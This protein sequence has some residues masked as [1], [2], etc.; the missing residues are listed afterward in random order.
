MQRISSRVETKWPRS[1]VVWAVIIVLAFGFP[2]VFLSVLYV[3][4]R[5]PL[6]VAP[7]LLFWIWFLWRAFENRRGTWYEFTPE[8]VTVHELSTDWRLRTT[9]RHL[10]L[11][12]REIGHFE[13]ADRE[14]IAFHYSPVERFTVWFAPSD[15]PARLAQYRTWQAA[16]PP[17]PMPGLPSGELELSR[18]SPGHWRSPGGVFECQAEYSR[19]VRTTVLR[20]KDRPVLALH[21]GGKL[22]LGAGGVALTGENAIAALLRRVDEEA[23]RWESN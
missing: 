15:V 5:S 23:A 13:A 10:E 18:V 3:I 8:G 6:V 12:W 11:R 1:P 21:E 17:P 22:V 4:V 16:D 14:S 20:E 2:A 7:F 9:V 19:G